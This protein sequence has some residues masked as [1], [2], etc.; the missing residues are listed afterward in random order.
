IAEHG[1]AER[2]GGA[3]GFGAGSNEFGCAIVAY[4]VACFFSQEDQAASR[5]AAETAFAVTGSFDQRAGGGDYG[6]GLFVDV[7]VAAEVARVVVRDGVV[8]G[9][10]RKLRGV[11]GH[12]LGVVFDF[13]GN[14]VLAPVGGDG[15]HAVRAYRND[16]FDLGF[17]EGSEPLFRERAEDQ[18]IA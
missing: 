8:L 15:A 14:A 9:L 6:A 1:V 17:F 7:L 10:L 5:P 3:D 11:A 18:V 4:A 13:G 12:E 2:T 16:L